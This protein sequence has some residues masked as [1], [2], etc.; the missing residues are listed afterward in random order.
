MANSYKEMFKGLKAAGE[1]MAGVMSFVEE[2]AENLT[3]EEKKE[4]SKEMDKLKPEIDKANRDIN[5]IINGGSTRS[6]SNK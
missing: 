6:G 1:G 5:K 4:L 3:E 2:M